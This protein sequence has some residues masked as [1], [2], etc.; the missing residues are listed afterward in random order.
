[1]QEFEFDI[2]DS[3]FQLHNLLRQREWVP[4]EYEDFFVRDPKLR[5]IHKATIRDRL[6][7]QALFR[8]LYPEFDKHFIYDSYSCR[9]YKGTHRGVLRLDSFIK[10]ASL[11][12]SIPTFALKCDIRKFFDNISHTILFQLIKKKIRDVDTLD[13]VSMIIKSFET[14]AGTGLPLGNV[15]SQLFANI[16][17]NE[18]DQY[19]KHTLKVK[20]YIRYCDDF[21]ILEND[22]A[23]LENYIKEIGIFLQDKLL[24]KL[25]PN[26]VIIC[27]ISQGIDFLGYV[28]FPHY[29]LLRKKTEKRMIRKIKYYIQLCKDNL[30]SKESLDSRLT[31]YLGVLTHCRGSK[32]KAKILEM[33]P[34]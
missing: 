1:M 22:S 27:K 7:H 20:Y 6:L 13:L 8:V 14:K 2:E 11:N 24:L 30:M 21:V 12:Y 17:L 28:I 3:I 16:Y 15:T 23:I 32:I 4:E 25:H 29:I 33:I 9:E 34:R 26:K 18:L 5:H 31:S 19:I 10:K